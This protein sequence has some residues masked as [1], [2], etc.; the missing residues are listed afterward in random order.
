MTK[1][2]VAIVHKHMRE[3]DN[4]KVFHSDTISRDDLDP[5]ESTLIVFDMKNYPYKDIIEIFKVTPL[6][7]NGEEIN[8]E[9]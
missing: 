1:D 2:Q 4:L 5:L 7:I 6:Y 3:C 9:S 8:N